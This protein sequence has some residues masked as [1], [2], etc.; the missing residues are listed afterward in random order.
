MY[1]IHFI[2]KTVLSGRLLQYFV[3]YINKLFIINN[4]NYEIKLKY[5]RNTYNYGDKNEI[6]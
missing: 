5:Y 3:T 4:N 2:N 6:L 1:K